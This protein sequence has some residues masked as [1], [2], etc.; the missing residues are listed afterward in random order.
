MANRDLH[1]SDLLDHAVGH[2]VG[3]VDHLLRVERRI[4]E[5]LV[6]DRLRAL[7]VRRRHVDDRLQVLHLVAQI[8]HV[9]ARLH[10][11]LHGRLHLLIE[12]HRGGKMKH[13]VYLFTG[14]LRCRNGVLVRGFLALHS[15]PTYVFGQ[16]FPIGGANAERGLHAVTGD[17]PYFVIV[18]R[19][20]LLHFVKHLQ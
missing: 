13:N 14:R 11:D 8:Q 2:A 18:L 7:R 5:P 17:R 20:R 12:S 4:V 16:N 3:Q 1:G 19:T 15:A 6:D 10:V 9:P